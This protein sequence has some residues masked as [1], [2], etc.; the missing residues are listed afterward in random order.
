MKNLKYIITG[1][2]TASAMM[3]VSPV[4]ASEDNEVQSANPAEKEVIEYNSFDLDKAVGLKNDAN[5]THE[6]TEIKQTSYKDENTLNVKEEKKETNHEDRS[7]IKGSNKNIS[8]NDIKKEQ[9]DE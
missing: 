3:L 4:L 5:L 9:S 1:L 7:E 2:F 8:I 6:K